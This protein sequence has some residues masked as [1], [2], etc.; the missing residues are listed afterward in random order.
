MGIVRVVLLLM[1]PALVGLAAVAAAQVYTV[2]AGEHDLVGAIETVVISNEET[3]ADVAREYNVGHE[4]IRLANPAVEFWLPPSGSDMV[5]PKR[6]ILPLA[7]RQ[8]I[9]LNVPEMRLYYFPR[10]CDR[11]AECTVFTHPVSI[12]RMDWKTP[13][14]TTHVASKLANPSWRPTKSIREEAAAE[15]NPLPEVVPPGPDN[16]LGA[17]ALYLGIP[18]YRI[19]GTNRPYGVG[20]RSTH[21]CVRMYPEDIEVLFESVPVGTLV[22]IVNQ[23]VKLGWEGTALYIEVHPPLEENAGQVQLAELARSELEALSSKRR[24]HLDEDEFA[25]ALIERTGMPVLISERTGTR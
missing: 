11:E 18:S 20:M 25:R 13:L 10:Y 23:P 2:P 14:G 1:S 22:K 24:V 21:G 16:P 12:G 6:H 3:L 8:G 15:G 17:H 4:E 19:H 9:V 7:R 5:L